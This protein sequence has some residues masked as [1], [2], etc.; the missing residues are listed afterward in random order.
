MRTARIA[1]L[2]VWSLLAS[3]LG[4][5][6]ASAEKRVALVIG[7]DSY[8]N[9]PRDQ[10]LLKAVNDANSVG[11]ALMRL[12]F[13]VLRGANLTR[14]QM[15]D[16]FDDLLQKLSPG[17]TVFFFFSGHGVSVGG[18]N[19]ILPVDVPNAAPGQE[20][21]L[22]RA[23]L[24]ENELVLDLQGRGVRVAIVVLDACRDNPFRRVGTRT[25]GGERGLARI[26]P[27]RGV[28]ALYSAGIGQTA[29][30]RL[31]NNDPNPNSVFTRVLVPTLA[32]P[33]LHLGDLALEVREEVSRIASSIGHTQHP[34][35][36]DET[37]GGRAYLAGLPLA[38][39]LSPPVVQ[40]PM[41]PDPAERA[42][43]R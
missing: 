7:N 40:T 14:Q 1:A 13:E 37:I 9:L 39:S 18:G 8:T 4:I 6:S 12:G 32:K 42:W 41:V 28:F 34:A 15:A 23:A 30:D 35:Y 24:S 25:I 11:D 26:D 27:V 36:Y 19:Y 33:G 5:S 31:S 3:L 43:V 21:R 20:S 2:I 10:Q 38:P 22:A 16:K 17:D 29:L